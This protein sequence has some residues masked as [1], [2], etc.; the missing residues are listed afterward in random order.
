MFNKTL[1]YTGTSYWSSI[2]LTFLMS[3]ITSPWEKSMTMNVKLYGLYCLMA[4]AAITLKTDDPFLATLYHTLHAENYLMVT[5]ILGGGAVDNHK[6]DSQRF[7]DNC[8]SPVQAL[9]IKAPAPSL[10]LVLYSSGYV[11]HHH[12]HTQTFSLVPGIPAEPKLVHI[13]RAIT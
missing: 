11:I 1:V 7:G 5:E 12:H 4:V 9:S 6:A 10:G 2:I 3:R 13:L 8:N